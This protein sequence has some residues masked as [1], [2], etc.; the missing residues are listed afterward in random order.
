MIHELNILNFQSHKDTSLTFDPGVN[1]IIGTSDSGKSAVIRALKWAIWN[2]PRGESF[3][4]W[5]GGNTIV[6]IKF[7]SDS[8]ISRHRG[9]AS[10]N[11]Y[12][13]TINGTDTDYAAPGN[14]VP[15]E[16]I[17]VHKMDNIN[18]QEQINAPFLLSENSGE[19]ARHFNK[20]AK[21]DTI[22]SSIKSAQRLINEVN[23]E[24][25]NNTNQLKAL[26]VS[27][28]SMEYL[29]HVS[30]ILER[31]SKLDKLENKND[32]DSKYIESYQD[33]YL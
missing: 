6:K 1:I 3:R 30:V 14:D 27:I 16:V 25:K 29:D 10:L 15:E 28:D 24:I 33:V 20:M 4:S 32:I 31:L 17:A 22:D 5:W 2:R 8:W 26:E 19:V 11:K 13:T 21:L 23:S 18:L 7:D 9:K 12:T